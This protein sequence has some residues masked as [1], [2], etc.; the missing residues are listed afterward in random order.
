MTPDPVENGSARGESSGGSC[1]VGTSGW[2]YTS[3]KP[4]FY[5]AKLPAKKFLEHYATRL[6]SVE[7]NY[8]FRQ[9][10]SRG[11]IESWLGAAGEQFRFSFKVPQRVTHFQKLKGCAG[12]MGAFL[13]SLTPVVDA[14]RMG[15][16]LI[17]LPPTFK[18][19][20]GQLEC[21]L[22]ESR[23]CLGSAE[24]RMA[25]EFRNASWFSDEAFEVLRHFKVALCVAES[26][27]L[28]TPDVVTA[29]FACYRLRRSGYQA[30]DLDAVVEKLRRRAQDGDVFAYFKHEEEPTGALSAEHVLRALRMDAS[31]ADPLVDCARTEDR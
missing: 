2:A 22:E 19:D 16:V 8:T 4:G 13:D 15:V 24:L 18:A 6:N 29:P 14:G 28:A 1:Y 23:G 7:V 31:R 10:P 21:F 9:L 20:I 17:Q 3:W 5:P 12:I 27:D 11:M 25:I 30:A 26:D